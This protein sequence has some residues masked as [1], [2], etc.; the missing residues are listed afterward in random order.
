MPSSSPP[1]RRDC[2]ACGADER[3]PLLDMPAVPAFCNVLWPTRADALAA[4]RGHIAL[5]LCRRCGLI[6]NA[7]FDPALVRYG[8]GYE[9]SLDSSP[10]FRAF[11]RD[12]ARRLVERYEL[13]GKRVVDIGCGDGRFLELLCDGTGNRGRGFDPSYAGPPAPAPGVEIVSEAFTAEHAAIPADL[14]ACRHVLEHLDD[15]RGLLRTLRDSQATLYFEVPDGDHMLRETAC[16]DVIYEH[17]SHFTAAALRRLFEDAGF[18]A[19]E[20]GSSFG[21]QYLHIEAAPGGTGAASPA[22]DDVAPLAE[23]FGKRSAAKI[24]L[25]ATR[26]AEHAA[27]GRSVALWGAGSKGVTFLNVVPGGER[28]E[29]VVDLNPRKQGRFVPGTGH[30]VVAPE[31][32]RERPPDL[33]LAANPLYVGEIAGALGDLDIAADVVAV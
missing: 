13:C 24:E 2:P 9:N 26:L 5:R 27:G 21:G 22:A 8:P 23:G 15:P 33:V 6:H 10:T 1:E 3:L 11:A 14:I 16:W 20:V 12:L 17:V 7:A 18:R 31:A 4:P 19:L 29:Q 25:W 32:L 30:A 28:V